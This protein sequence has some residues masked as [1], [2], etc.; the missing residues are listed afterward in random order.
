MEGIS[1]ERE[2]VTTMVLQWVS[3]RSTKKWKDPELQF[4]G[5]GTVLNT[6]S[7]MEVVMEED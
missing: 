3:G 5:L 7:S 2:T 1:R 6:A 4:L